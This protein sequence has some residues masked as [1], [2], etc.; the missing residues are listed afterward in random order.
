MDLRY[1]LHQ[2]YL[3]GYPGLDTEMFQNG[4]ALADYHTKAGAST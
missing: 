2:K 3:R 4:I 1:R